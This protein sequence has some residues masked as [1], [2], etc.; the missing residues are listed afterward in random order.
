MGRTIRRL[1]GV[2]GGIVPAVVEAQ[3]AS[4]AGSAKSDAATTQSSPAAQPAG[5]PTPGQNSPAPVQFRGADGKPLPPEIQRK[6][7]EQLRN[8]P[9]ALLGNGSA[10]QQRGTGNDILVTTRRARGAVIGDVPPERTFG[11]LDIRALGADNIGALLDILGPQLASARGREDGGPVVLLNGRR[12]TSLL[13]VARIPAEAIERMEVFPEELALRYGYRA[14]QKV[15]N[16]VTLERFRSRIGQ[17]GLLAPTEGGRESGTGKVDYLAIRGDTRLSLGAT[18][19][20]AASLLES[21]RDLRQFVGT[22]ELGQFRTLLPS[23]DQVTLEGVV[24]GQLPGDIAA[25]LN[26]RFEGTRTESLLGAIGTR[27]LRR[28]SDRGIAHLGTTLG[29]PSGPWLWTVTASHDRSTSNTRTDLGDGAAGREPARSTD[30]RTMADLLLN[31]PIVQLP[32]GPLSASAHAAVEVSTFDSRWGRGATAGHVSPS[33]QRGAA[34]LDLDLPI[35]HRGDKHGAVLG[36]LSANVNLALEQLSDAGRLRSF[37]YGLRWS[38]SSAVGV[39]LSVAD[40][41]T[42]PTLEQLGAPLLVTP[43][44]RTFDLVR[45]EVVDTT[46]IFGGNAALRAEDRHLVKLGVTLR[47]IPRT[48]LTLSIDYVASRIDSPIAAFPILTPQIEDAFPGRFTRRGDGVL[49][50]IDG[51]PL[52]FADA[53]QKQ[54]RWGVNFVRPLGPVPPGLQN[55]NVRVFGSEAEAR[56]AFPGAVF[57]QADPGSAAARSIGNLSSRLFLSVY[58]NWY[59]EDSI[60]PRAGVAR[61]DLLDG[62]A[63]DVRG[64]RRRHEVEFQAGAFKRGLGAR[65]TVNWQSGT[66][67][68]GW[69]SA[70]GDLH[71]GGYAVVNLTVFANLAERLG[72]V[73]APKWL[74][75]ARATLGITNLFNTRPSVRDQAGNT[76]LSYQPAYLDPLGR[77]VSFT[78]RKSF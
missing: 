30:A 4:P 59:F 45:Q 8:N 72:G 70:Q 25:T 37:G 44:V 3:Q 68:R 46:R 34:Q 62:G 49:S 29:G 2:I 77:M 12:V 69:G 55:G 76:P 75:G 5:S 20:R 61:L 10:Q 73:H 1:V 23:S 7:E 21:E 38:P 52:N 41:Q 53:R 65:M 63:V 36:T 48:D 32:A 51:R 78:L 43:N 16:V 19:T 71:F 66:E 26:G 18:Y 15:L 31:G 22:P 28:H 67:I 17:L 35:F 74:K 39:I 58:H 42:A 40:D 14:D 13:E 6:L 50:A 57:T 56:R 33:R 54:L 24:S 47:P 27:S 60:L 64:G 11:P 9:S